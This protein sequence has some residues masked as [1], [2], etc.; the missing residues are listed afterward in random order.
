MGV[1]CIRN[2]VDGKVYIGS[3]INVHK[4]LREHI[5][6]LANGRHCNIL[7]TRSVNKYGASNFKFE[8]I[9]QIGDRA[10]LPAAEQKWMEHY[11][12]HDKAKGFNILPT[13]YSN[14]G[15]KA[16]AETKKG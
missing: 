7:L 6:E 5:F 12:S 8:L 15:H 9:E 10:L 16:T 14:S 11:G 3:S 2:V 13:A 1:Y 4:R